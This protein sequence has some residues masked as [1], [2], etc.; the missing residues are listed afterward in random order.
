MTDRCY[1][2]IERR[3][4]ETLL[5]SQDIF[6]Y[7]EIITHTKKAGNS[8]WLRVESQLQSINRRRNA[9]EMEQMRFSGPRNAADQTQVSS[10]RSVT[11]RTLHVRKLA[12]QNRS[13]PECIDD[14]VK[15]KQR[16]RSQVLKRLKQGQLMQAINLTCCFERCAIGREPC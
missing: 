12:V 7:E 13:D 10:P 1:E 5:S 16:E 6:K 15:S 14:Q 8:A 9:L 3:F 4:I 11:Q 2:L